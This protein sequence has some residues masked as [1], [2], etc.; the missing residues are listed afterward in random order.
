MAWK[1]SKKGVVMRGYRCPGQSE[2]NLKAELYPCPGCDH[3]VEIFSDELRARCPR[4]GR[5]VYREKTPSCIDWCKAA[6][7]C[8]GSEKWRKLKG[9][10]N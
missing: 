7:Q 3:K 5:E 6:E 2:R 9:K 1:Q 8:L 10:R 4:C